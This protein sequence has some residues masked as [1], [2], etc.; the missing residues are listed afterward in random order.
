MKKLF[1]FIAALAVAFTAN[2]K[3]TTISPDADNDAL[4]L[5]VYYAEDGDIIEMTEGTY[6]QCNDGYV[7]FDGK[8]VTV[9]AA[10]GANVVLQLQVPITLANGG[11]ATLENIKIDASRLQEIANWYEHVIYTE[12]ATDGKELVMEGCELYGF[13]LNKSAIYSKAENK[14]DL[15][16]IN[17]CYFHDNMKSCFFFEGASIAE[18]SV[19]NSTF[20]NIATNADSYYAG[21]IDVRNADAKVTIDHCTFYDCKAMNT[22]YATVTMK[23]PQAANV[24]ISNNIFA[25]SSDETAMRAIRNN[26]NAKNCLTF[27]YKYSSDSNPGL[28][29]SVVPT[30]CKL[31]VDPMFVAAANGNFAL[32]EGSPALTAGTD[33][34]AIGDPRWNAP[35]VE[36]P[37]EPEIEWMEMELEINNLT[38]EV[39]EIEDAKYLRLNG[40]NDMEDADVTLFLNNYADVDDDYAVN[41][42][43]SYLTY[44][45]M[46]LTVIEGTISQV[47]E[48]ENGTIYQGKV[49]A[50]L[51]DEEEG[52]TMY[53][54]FSILM[55]TA[56][57]TPLVLTN[58][59]V[60]INEETGTLTFNVPTEEG[61]GY[62]VE[63]AGYTEPGVYE[64]PQVCLLLT[65]EV[66]AYGTYA[67]VVVENNVYTLTCKGMASMMG[68][69]FDL[70]VSGTVQQGPTGVENLN[71]AV[72]PV[73]VIE[74]GQI[75]IIR[76]GVKYNAQGAKL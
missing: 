41:A 28:H 61:E 37:V 4:R 19:V 18:L 47:S 67:E 1:F 76:N 40:R 39:M 66:A 21:P 74:N 6:V 44:G 14:L 72:A 33:G 30:D 45:G 38:T 9:R 10:E 52:G 31:N 3:V 51:T 64:G 71:G 42:E 13:N 59:I 5:A 62:Y 25:L 43:G 22:D 68:S 8:A 34:K 7:A 20:A 69:R 17:N 53:L 15:C 49:R 16:K 54:E 29:S 63:L 70:T 60:A 56:P 65:P 46:E 58:A 73:K 75:F 36:E 11:K 35:A 27:N 24:V 48:T 12:D 23:G 26:V 55:Y 50:S 2:A 32:A 57:A